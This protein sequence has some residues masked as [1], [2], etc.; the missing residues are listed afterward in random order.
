MKE[1]IL[2]G[3]GLIRWALLRKVNGREI[4]PAGFEDAASMSST[5]AK[6]LILPKITSLEEDLKP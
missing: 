5:A 4:S 1:I 2:G 6:K 3:P